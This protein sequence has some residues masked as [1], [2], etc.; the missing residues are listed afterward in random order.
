L[1]TGVLEVKITQEFRKIRG[2][3][4]DLGAERR[5][6]ADRVFELLKAVD[7]L[8]QLVEASRPV[9]GRN[10]RPTRVRGKAKSYRIEQ[11]GKDEV[12]AEY[13]EDSDLPFRCPRSTY[14]AL[15]RGLSKSDKPVKFGDLVKAITKESG[16]APADYQIRLALRFWAQPEVGLVERARAR[17]RP[18]LTAGFVEASK[19]AW[20][21]AMP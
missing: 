5:E 17:Y 6:I 16:S 15:A 18:K 12:L 10:D 19:R 21:A 1:L 2:M 4:T 8:E 13:R 20:R 11:V 3:L 9:A 7:T 14:D